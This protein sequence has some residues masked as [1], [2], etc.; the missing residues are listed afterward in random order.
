[1]HENGVDPLVS[2]ITPGSPGLRGP[3]EPAAAH[4][5]SVAP[6]QFGSTAEGC[7]GFLCPQ[8]LAE[9]LSV[10]RRY[11]GPRGRDRAGT[12]AAGGRHHT[13][14]G[15]GRSRR[16]SHGGHLLKPERLLATFMKQFSGPAHPVPGHN[17]AC[18]GPQIMAGKRL[19]A[20]MRSVVQCSPP[21]RA[22]AD[23][24]QGA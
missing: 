3:R 12:C 13:P 2:R 9:A 15:H 24:A 1:L 14:H 17:L 19:A 18:R 21:Q 22:R 10:C 23:R 6:R 20:T 4:L 11:S 5:W 7:A 16:Q 8:D